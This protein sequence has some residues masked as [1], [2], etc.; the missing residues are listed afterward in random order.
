M[1]L[2]NRLFKRSRHSNLST[3][4]ERQRLSKTMPGQTGAI[5]AARLGGLVM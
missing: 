4:L 2:F 1:N 3:R 5:S